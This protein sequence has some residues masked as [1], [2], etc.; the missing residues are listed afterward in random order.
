VHDTRSGLEQRKHAERC[1]HDEDSREAGVWLAAAARTID[2]A[3]AEPYDAELIEHAI[4]LLHETLRRLG[5]T[6]DVP[7]RRHLQVVP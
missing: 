7:P 4:V 2:H 1:P 6:D 3:A 5:L